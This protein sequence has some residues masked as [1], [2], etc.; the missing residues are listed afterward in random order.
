[1]SSST[2]IKQDASTIADAVKNLPDY[3]TANCA[4]SCTALSQYNQATNKATVAGARKY[5]FVP[6]SNINYS[7]VMEKFWAKLDACAGSATTAMTEAQALFE[8]DVL[9]ASVCPYDASLCYPAPNFDYTE[10]GPTC[11]FKAD[12]TMLAASPD[13]DSYASLGTTLVDEYFDFGKALGDVGT[14][15]ETLVITLFLALIYGFLF[16]VL[17]RFAVAYIVWGS[18]LAVFL[19]F[20]GGGA[21]YYIQATVC[22][23]DTRTAE[24]PAANG[25]Y[26]NTEGDRSLYESVAYVMFGLAA[27]YFLFILIMCGRIQL[28]IAINKVAARFVY[29]NKGIIF[30]PVVQTF[31]AMIWWLIWLVCAM[32]IMATIPAEDVPNGIYTYDEAYGTDDTAGICTGDANSGGFFKDTLTWDPEL[33]SDAVYRCK[34]AQYNMDARFAYAFFSLLW[35]NALIIAVGQCT[36]A[37]AVAYWYFT[38]NEEKGLNPTIRPALRNC[39]RYHL[40]SLCFGSFILACVQFVKWW[41]YYLQKQAEAT[42]NQFAALLAKIAQYLIACFERCIKFLNKNAYIQ[43]ALL[44]KNFCMSAWNA[45]ML[46]I[47]NAARIGVLAGIGFIVSLLGTV[48]IMLAT[49]MSGYF[50]LNALYEDGEL[51]SVWLLTFFYF[52]IGFVIAKLFMMVFGLAADSVLQCFIADEE[53]NSKTEGG[54]KNTPEELKAFMKQPKKGCC[55]KERRTRLRQR[56]RQG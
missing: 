16:V 11:M 17:L 28:G 38:K 4:L 15:W 51:Y 31:A 55:A 13:A 18:I 3:F 19:M 52:V 26:K 48:F 34:I 49:G 9:P 6:D 41:M 37:G 43:I 20:F 46:I 25:G 44:G 40:G 45:F 22:G 23:D 5:R 36:V 7:A 21:Y 39:F 24:C 54:A 10:I 42:K 14:A 33:I 50:I 29:Q 56:Q 12:A 2:A 35:T 8:F 32:F 30:L 1:M 53:I 27:A 47:R